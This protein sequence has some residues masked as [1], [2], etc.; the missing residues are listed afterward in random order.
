MWLMTRHGFYSIVDKGEMEG[1]QIRARERKDLENLFGDDRALDYDTHQILETPH[2]DYRYR[3]I[4]NQVRLRS[5]LHWLG[6][7]IDYPNFKGEID[8]RPDQR[9][10]PYHEVW[11]VLAR[12][13]G[14]YGRGGA[15]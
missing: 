14:S 15:A 12:A 8:K 7:D 1:I 13:L 10:K 6:N 3:V 11:N 2:N 9:R 4:V 5:V